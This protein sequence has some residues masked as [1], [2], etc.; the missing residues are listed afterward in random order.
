[1]SDQ[2]GNQKVGFLM[3][4]LILFPDNQVEVS[5]VIK[6]LLQHVGGMCLHLIQ[7]DR[8]YTPLGAYMLQQYPVDF[9]HLERIWD[10]L[11]SSLEVGHSQTVICALIVL[12]VQ[13]FKNQ[14]FLL[15]SFV[16]L[17]LSFWCA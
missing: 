7:S 4:R 12:Q 13:R 6:L 10:I 3:T 15:S 14:P 17:F 9:V 1:M 11:H 2:V 5:E 8:L 16:C